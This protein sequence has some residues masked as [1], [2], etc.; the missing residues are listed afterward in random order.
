LESEHRLEDVLT[1]DWSTG[2]RLTSI[3]QAMERLGLPD[4]PGL[5]W[6]LAGRLEGQWRGTLLGP[7]KQREILASLGRLPD[8][9]LAGEGG[10][11]KRW[12]DQVDT[13]HPASI[14]LS[15]D[16]KLVARHILMAHREGLSL[17]RPEETAAVLGLTV[18][19]VHRALRMLGLIDFLFIEDGW[20]AAHYSLNEGHERLLDGLG[21]SFHTVTLDTGERFGIS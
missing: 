16:E 11:S 1:S 19:G 4:D 14:L 12:A 3:P 6:R 15:E 21:F 8:E 10:F 2:L 20:R 13:W 18:Q 17:P 7:E 9:A 5:R